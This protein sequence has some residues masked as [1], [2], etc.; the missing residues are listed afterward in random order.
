MR[1][2]Q[3]AILFAA[4]SVS[5]VSS[6][7]AGV[8]NLGSADDYSLL[9]TGSP[10]GGSMVLGSAVDIGGNIGAKD[11]VLIGTGS[12]IDGNVHGGSV[13]YDASTQITG[14]VETRSP[15]YWGQVVHDLKSAAQ[16]AADL[17]GVKWGEIKDA[18]TLNGNGLT[19][20]HLDGL[21]L[22]NGETL[23]LEGDATTEFV[24]N[25]SNYLDLNSGA[26]I[27]ALGGLNPANVT[28]N[29]MDG[30]MIRMNNATAIGTFIADDSFVQLGDGNIFEETRFLGGTIQGNLQRLRP[31]SFI[32][33]PEPGVIGFLLMGL[34][35]IFLVRR[36]G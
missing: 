33:I 21:S 8:I 20:F 7:L 35:G 29:M 14:T 17:G 10:W 13:H 28:F 6:A 24:I 23:F 9:A 31:P 4:I 11:S 25:V 16:Q 18:T 3:G 2:V 27:V 32:N 36:R 12:M 5:T 30:A 26:R 15:I 1:W 22:D 34:A 19:V